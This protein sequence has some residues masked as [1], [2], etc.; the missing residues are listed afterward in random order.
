MI[1][2]KNISFA[3]QD[4]YILNDITLTLESNKIYG[5]IGKNGVGK[6]TLLKVLSRYINT[7]NGNIIIDSI[8]INHTDFLDTN[9]AY[10]FDECICFNELTFV[11]HLI[12][13]AKS[14][15]LS[16]ESCMRFIHSFIM[17]LDLD[18]YKNNYPNTL[19]KGTLQRLN[20]GMGLIRHASYLLMDEPFNGLDP[21]QTTNCIALIKNY[22]KEVKNT[23]IISSHQLEN[24]STLCDD[25]LIMTSSGILK[26][27]KD[28]INEKDI[29]EMLSHDTVD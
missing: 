5:L 27:Q 4:V 3:Y 18:K 8:S 6:T 20:I 7:N 23:I 12:L 15:G 17:N 11:E 9:I 10:V 19:S 2:L 28:Q 1:E 24:L 29:I 26:I 22:Q 25:Y 21:V 14:S 16:K 13:I